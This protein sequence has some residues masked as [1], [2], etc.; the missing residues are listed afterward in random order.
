MSK[1]TVA[2]ILSLK[3]TA[4]VRKRSAYAQ[5]LI[6]SDINSSDMSAEDKAFATRLVYGVVGNIST[7]DAVINRNLNLPDDIDA[8]VRDALRLS[9]YELLFLEKDS[10]AAVDQG[11]EL[12]RYCAPR[13]AGLANAVLRK[14]VEDIKKFPYGN[15]EEDMQAFALQ[16]GYP[17]WLAEE[18]ISDLGE[19]DARTLMQATD[20][21]APLYM[22]RN[23][24]KASEEEFLLAFE[25][26]GAQPSNGPVPN[27]YCMGNPL[28]AINCQA[29]ADGWGVVADAS[30]Q[31]AAYFVNPVP[32]TP[33]LEIGAGRGTKTFLLQA[34]AKLRGG[35]LQIFAND[36]Y[37]F[38]NRV[39]SSRLSELGIKGVQHFC[40]DATK[41]QTFKQQGMPKRFPFAFIDAPCSNIGTL[42]RHPEQRNRLTK[43]ELE[44]VSK[45]QLAMLCAVSKKIA[46]GGSLVYSTCSPL[47]KEDNMVIN[48]FLN[49]PEG[50]GFEVEHFVTQAQ[51][52]EIDERDVTARRAL[53]PLVVPPA[54]ERFICD[55]GFIRI[56]PEIN[57]PDG[58][59]IARLIRIS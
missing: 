30:A 32:G 46:V 33:V 24:F 29:F 2:R 39:A 34:N 43:P 37:D 51:L 26:A 13:A 18:L 50:I 9:T 52:D 10:Y 15:V 59:F 55:E 5:N 38:K 1:L 17:Y 14:I 16:H 44:S 36:Y 7:L 22:A 47:H 4:E 58:H 54:F 56:I 40:G 23:P 20:A 41:D 31:L 42:R 27:C 11:V 25:N 3:V 57:G 6:D 28:A 8:T 49:S 21:S 19:K 12:V 35:N 48:E 45:L 53:Q